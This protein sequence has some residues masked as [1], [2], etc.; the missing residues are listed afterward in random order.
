VKLENFPTFVF[1]DTKMMLVHVKCVT[2]WFFCVVAAD[3]AKLEIFMICF[4][5]IHR[6]D[7]CSCEFFAA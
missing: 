2:A 1:T 5:L 3:S 7:A 6:N 4:L